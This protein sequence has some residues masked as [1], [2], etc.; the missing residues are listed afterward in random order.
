VLRFHG[1]GVAAVSG[2]EGALE[3]V[4]ATGVARRIAH[5]APFAT[6]EG[7]ELTL[8]HPTSGLR[9]IIAVR[10]GVA[11]D[12]ALDSRASD[13]LAGL[14]PAPLAAG[15][16]LGV[17]DSARHPVEPDVTPRTLPASGELVDLEITLGPRDDWFTASA[18]ATLTGQ[19]WTVT[20]R[21]DRVG[22]RLEGAVP[23]ERS[24]SG[25][26]PSEG[27]V[28]G[29]IQVPPDGQPVLFLPDHPLTSGYT[30]IGALTDRSL[31]LAGQLPP[32]VRVRFTVKETS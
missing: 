11:V 14:G 17:G 1:S 13:T 26:L 24:V 20:P 19:E 12:P 15:D 18:L 28:T 27:A 10:G 29:A 32:G 3:L 21:S 6:V 9:Y 8:G 2:A 23:L 5:G 4:D 31:D 30:I 16:V 25:E 22:I 7:D